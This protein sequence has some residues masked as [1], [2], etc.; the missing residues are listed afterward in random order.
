MN[1]HKT[2]IFLLVF[3]FFFVFSQGRAVTALDSFDQKKTFRIEDWEFGLNFRQPPLKIMNAIGIK[4]GMVV[5]EIGA[6]TGRMTMWLA[7][8][9]GENG[10]VYANDIDKEALAHL[11]E[12]CRRDG[13]ENVEIVL[14]ETT[15]PKLPAGKLDIAFMINV[16][17]HLADPVPVIRNILPSLKEDGLLAVVECDPE[18]VEWGAGHGCSTS[19]K[20]TSELKEAGFKI[21]RVETFLKEDNIYIAKVVSLKQRQN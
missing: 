13:F 8:R 3:L 2:G 15:D 1:N 7:Q 11:R 10:R 5:G 16:Y 19:E 6:G 12:R 9:V 17:H 20:M 14:G 18:K 4:P 21:I